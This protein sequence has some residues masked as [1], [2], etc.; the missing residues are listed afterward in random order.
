MIIRTSEN[1]KSG[2]LID[3]LFIANGDFIEGKIGNDNVIGVFLIERNSFFFLQNTR[4]GGNPSIDK[5]PFS[6]SWQFNIDNNNKKFTQGVQIIKKID[7][8]NDFKLPIIEGF[9]LVLDKLVYCYDDILHFNL[10]GYPFC[11]GSVILNNLELYENQELSINSYSKKEI[12]SLKEIFRDKF[13]NRNVTCILL[14][15]HQSKII[16]FLKDFLDFKEINTFINP[17]GDNVLV[18]LSYNGIEFQS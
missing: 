17:N 13:K 7:P 14:K 18:M 2:I 6:G 8:F 10:E 9:S 15:D 4:H 16:S 12:R 5:S 1:N 11:C 3:D